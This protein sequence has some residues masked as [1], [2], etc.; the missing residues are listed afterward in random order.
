MTKP[1]KQNFACSERNRGTSHRGSVSSSQDEN[2]PI[3]PHRREGPIQIER[4]VRCSNNP[5]YSLTILQCNLQSRKMLSAK[6]Q[7]IPVTRNPKSAYKFGIESSNYAVAELLMQVQR[8]AHKEL[9]CSTPFKSLPSIPDHPSV[10]STRRVR[11]SILPSSQP[12]FVS[13]SRR[14]QPPRLNP[15]SRKIS[16]DDEDYEPPGVVTP[17]TPRRQI[18]TI[19]ELG[20]HQS[21]FLSVDPL[22]ALA[23]PVLIETTEADVQK[24]RKSV[25]R[26]L[27]QGVKWKGTLRKKF[28]WKSF[29]ELETY[30][31]DHRAEYLQFSSSLNYTKAQKIYNNKL[32]QG[33]LDLAAS[34]GYTFEGFSFAAVRDRIRCFYKSYVQATKK[35]KRSKRSLMM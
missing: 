27:Q 4:C 7:P 32:T 28:S 31:V 13:S 2:I 19:H 1:I 18:A 6:I 33:L 24:K 5:D 20:I 15:R 16:M 14:T 21:C 11:P 10:T 17:N 29:P 3:A 30:L 22:S 25:G 23:P 34:C 12:S 35:K 9:K 26:T 8:I